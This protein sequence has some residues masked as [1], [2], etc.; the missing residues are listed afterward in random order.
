MVADLLAAAARRRPV[1]TASR[2]SASVDAC[3]DAEKPLG[4]L[5]LVGI[6]VGGTLGSGL[7]LLAGRA[8]RDVAGPAVT[9]SFAL[10]AIACLFSGMAYAEM[11]SRDPDCG[12][13]YA[14]AYS[15]LGELPAFLVG[16]C[17]TLEYGVASAAI[18]RSWASYVG[19]AFLALPNWAV[20]RDSFLSVFACIL[21][22]CITA[23]LS[24][25]MREAKWII[26][27][28]TAVYGVVVMAI[29][30]VG[31]AHVDK[32]NWDPFFPYGVTGVLAGAS[33]VFFSFIG[34]DEV[35]TVAEE[36]RNAAKNVPTAMIL[37]LAIVAVMYVGAT[38]V[39]TGMVNY[40]HIDLDAPFSAAFRSV[41]MRTV[42]KLIGL[43]TATGMMNTTLVSLAA[44][45]RIFVSMGRDG[46]LPRFI[47]ST[48]RTTTIRCGAVVSLFALA[49]PTELLAD[50]VSGGTLLAF[51]ATNLALMTSRI[52][53]H[54]EAG[55]RDVFMLA[56]SCFASG[57]VYRLSTLNI[58]PTAVAC[59]IAAVLVVLPSI[60]VFRLDMRAGPAY[61][62]VPP[63]F[64]CPF[65]PLFP[66]AG[67]ATTTF[68][69]TQLPVVALFG[70]FG[71]LGIAMCLYILYGMHN[72]V[73]DSH[74]L[75][76]NQSL[77][78]YDG[79]DGPS[80]K[81]STNEIM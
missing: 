3:A 37:S 23:V 36:A 16:C 34:F 33:H 52:R 46:L 28:S 76:N 48:T 15:A 54:S 60:A 8:A 30:A 45:P 35:A 11:S 50:V 20:G 44:Q 17:L 4:L 10:A 55:V 5:D 69:L 81:V 65:V 79:V 14:F 13:A 9:V 21:V 40:A 68:L 61:E 27:V 41:H 26:N 77:S 39:L 53:I 2:S 43:G 70:M 47:A 6:G 19:E 25:G 74:S 57:V 58:V 7:F 75:L 31:S 42:A 29:V 66:I 12:G 73:A 24:A 63:V 56:G 1:V 59:T 22:L 38:L 64:F 18:A 72:S 71:W 49:A 78:T 62:E 32:S 51:L 80:P 67:V